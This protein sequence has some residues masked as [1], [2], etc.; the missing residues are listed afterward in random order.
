MEKVLI[1]NEQEFDET[2][3]KAITLWPQFE[4]GK[5]NYLLGKGIGTEIALKG[6]ALN[7][8]KNHN[9]FS[10]RTHSDLELYDAKSYDYPDDFVKEFGAQEI[11]LPTEMKALRNLPPNLMDENFDIVEYKGNKYG[12]LNFELLFLEKYLRK[13]NTPRKEGY[14]AILLAKE[15]DLN[16]DKVLEYYYNY[17]YAYEMK[18]INE[19]SNPER[20]NDVISSINKLIAEE[21]NHLED[22]DILVNKDTLHN[23]LSSLIQMLKQNHIIKYGLD[24]DILPD[25]LLLKEVNGIYQISENQ[26]E[27]IL[28][29]MAQSKQKESDVLN[30]QRYNIEHLLYSLRNNKNIEHTI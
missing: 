27:E 13:E 29:L 20:I 14:D 30:Q 26:R 18:K 9:N 2:I 6:E 3:K 22:D 5:I 7:R 8:K 10:F 11:F 21:K 19:K 4:N 17:F 12:I 16:I 15:Y 1:N 24:P 25:D 28:S 23:H